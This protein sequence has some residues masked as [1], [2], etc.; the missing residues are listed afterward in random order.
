MST[1]IDETKTL[2]ISGGADDTY[3]S[4]VQLRT[5]TAKVQVEVG[6]ATTDLDIFVEGRLDVDIGWA[7]IAS[8]ATVTNGYSNIWTVDTDDL[9]E[10]RIRAVNNDGVNGGDVTVVVRTD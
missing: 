10:L 1:P 2:T 4:A 7:T 6:G 8:A 3:S 5:G 9:H